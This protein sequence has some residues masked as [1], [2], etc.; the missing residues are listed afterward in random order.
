[1]NMIYVQQNIIV[2]RCNVFNKKK[3]FFFFCIFIIVIRRERE[4][5]ETN[6]GRQE[7]FN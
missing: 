7:V 3:V 2:V 5:K 6:K 1:M 4:K